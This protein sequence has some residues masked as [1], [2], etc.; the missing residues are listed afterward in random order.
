M[1]VQVGE[2]RAAQRFV[3]G[4]AAGEAVVELVHQKHGGTVVHGPQRGD[5][6]GGASSTYGVAEPHEA[7]AALGVSPG[8]RTS[9]QHHEVCANVFVLDL[10]EMEQPIVGALG[11]TGKHDV[12]VERELRVYNGVCSQVDDPGATA[13]R[14]ERH[15]RRLRVERR[16]SLARVRADGPDLLADVGKGR[17]I[18]RADTHSG[19]SVERR[20]AQRAQRP[21]RVRRIGLL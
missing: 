3:F 16:S 13:E 10:V 14:F 12:A 6:C 18:A 20:E 5:G 8:G 17:H 9:T 19:P 11:V 7:F 1:R 21:R 2:L 4:E 15:L